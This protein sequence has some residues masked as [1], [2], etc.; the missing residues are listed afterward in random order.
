[1]RGE[2]E[3]DRTLNYIADRDFGDETEMQA[4]PPETVPIYSQFWLTAED[5]DTIRILAVDEQAGTMTVQVVHGHPYFDLQ[6]APP[7]T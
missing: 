4:A 2:R 5:G 6:T 7:M 1:M 3:G